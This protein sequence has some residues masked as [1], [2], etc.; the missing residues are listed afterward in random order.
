MK[1]PG[2][3]LVRFKSFGPIRRYLENQLIE[4]EVPERATVLQVIRIV[5]DLGGSDLKDL[6][7]KNGEIDGNLIVMLNK[8]DVSTISGVEHSVNEGD[9]IALLPHVQGG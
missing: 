9:E 8:K 2:T 1:F 6:I 7:L 4:V 3:M 5:A